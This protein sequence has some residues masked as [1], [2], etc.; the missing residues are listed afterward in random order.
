MQESKLTT[1]EELIQLL[2]ALHPSI[3]KG[4]ASHEIII[5]FQANSS[6]QEDIESFVSEIQ[7][8]LQSSN[9]GFVE[10]YGIDEDGKQGEFLINCREHTDLQATF[11][12]IRSIFNKYTFL[13]QSVV[14]IDEKNVDGEY[15][16][17]FEVVRAAIDNDFE[18]DD[19]ELP[20]PE[21]FEKGKG[22]MGLIALV[23]VV[24][25]VLIFV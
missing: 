8:E 2:G 17:E 15:N 16:F 11:E 14:Y 23:S 22:C 19:V 6:N 21:G 25:A 12:Q 10:I 18:V 5:V 9:L 3:R 13:L 7:K 24:I 4:R 1:E 20:V